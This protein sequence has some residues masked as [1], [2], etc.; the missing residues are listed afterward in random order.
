MQLP[1]DN[2]NDYAS[3]PCEYRTERKEGVRVFIGCSDPDRKAEHFKEDTWLYRHT[4]TAYHASRI[5][6]GETA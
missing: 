6:E 3:Q 1:C 5:M 2:G 4:C